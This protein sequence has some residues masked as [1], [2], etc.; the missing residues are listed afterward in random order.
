M[1]R[2]LVSLDEK[3]K[4]KFKQNKWKVRDSK[5]SNKQYM[6]GKKPF[7]DWGQL[8]K[9]PT[10]SYI[11]AFL[12]PDGLLRLDPLENSIFNPNLVINLCSLVHVRRRILWS[13]K[14]VKQES[15]KHENDSVFFSTSVNF[16]DKLGNTV[17]HMLSIGSFRRKDDLND[18]VLA[19]TRIAIAGKNLAVV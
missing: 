10:T 9:H 1:C 3:K 11:S 8:R 18:L 15:T 6:I 2:E 16:F 4:K 12:K 17:I 5:Q 19:E 13:K 14:T 7:S